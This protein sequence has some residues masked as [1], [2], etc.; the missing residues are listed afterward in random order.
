M[1][2]IVIYFKN[3]RQLQIKHTASSNIRQK[4]STFDNS[5]KVT[6]TTIGN[7]I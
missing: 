2:E 5:V 1:I 7:M 6:V 3:A 4:L